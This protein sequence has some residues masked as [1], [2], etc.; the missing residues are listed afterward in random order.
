MPFLNHL[1][2]NV[3]CLFGTT[4][5][6]LFKRFSV[7]GC[8][9][10]GC[11]LVVGKSCHHSCDVLHKLCNALEQQFAKKIQRIFQTQMYMKCVF[12]LFTLSSARIHKHFVA[13]Q[14]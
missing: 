3:K 10:C 9:Q 5:D 13:L 4:S 8:M 6:S 11:N 7:S 14:L 12:L 2:F 1:C